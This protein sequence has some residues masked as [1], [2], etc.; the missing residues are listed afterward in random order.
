MAFTV[1]FVQRMYKP[2]TISLIIID[3]YTILLYTHESKYPIHIE[4]R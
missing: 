2:I 3:K 4:H 1:Y